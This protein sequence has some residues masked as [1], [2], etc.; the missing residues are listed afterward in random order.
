M[1]SICI[2]CKGKGLCGKPCKILTRFMDKAP[3]V[4]THFSGSTPPE[5]FVG[6]FGYPN[7][8]SGI[9]SPVEFGNTLIFSSPKKWVEKN[10]SIE[11]ILE[12]R[13]QMIYARSKSHIKSQKKLTQEMQELAMAS[14]STS[15]EFFLKKKPRLEF[16][17]NR[18]FTIM[19]N[20]AP[21]QKLILEENTKIE[22]KVDYLVSDYNVK[23]TTAVQELYESKILTSNIQKILS[24]GLLGVKTQRKLVPTR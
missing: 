22:P 1:E 8:F 16:T 15:V 17:S 21:I 12:Y 7:I 23:A 3:K 18:V 11:Q 10:L 6:R 13:G 14:K 9:L 2:R 19:A 4:K 20:P 24:A 5:I